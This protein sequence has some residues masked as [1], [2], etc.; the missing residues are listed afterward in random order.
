MGAGRLADYVSGRLRC[1]RRLDGNR[2]A[3]SGRF[4]RVIRQAL[5]VADGALMAVQSGIVNMAEPRAAVQRQGQQGEHPEESLPVSLN[6]RFQSRAY[7]PKV[8]E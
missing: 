1:R 7:H 5:D 6:H 4:S 2:D 3:V 8:V